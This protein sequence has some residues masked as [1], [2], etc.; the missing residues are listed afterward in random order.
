MVKDQLAN[1]TFDAKYEG[2]F[3]VVHRTSRGTYVLR[4]L[5]DDILPRNYA[6]EQM[7]LVI[8]SLDDENDPDFLGHFEV[9]AI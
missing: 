8:Q 4:D 7:K 1:S 3:Q 2:P 5:T 9:E 6:P